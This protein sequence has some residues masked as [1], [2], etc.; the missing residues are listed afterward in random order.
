MRML[1]FV[2]CAVFLTCGAATAA[3]GKLNFK[4]TS[5]VEVPYGG[6][7]E[8][9]YVLDVF[10]IDA[11]GA[12]DFAVSGGVYDDKLDQ[13]H[14]FI[15]RNNTDTGK[16]QLFDLGDEGLTHSAWH[17]LFF[18]EGAGEQ[19][20]FVLGRNGEA[21]N[22][23]GERLAIF[24][25]TPGD[26]TLTTEP[27]FTSPFSHLTMTVTGCDIDADG[28]TEIF[29]NNYGSPL[30]DDSGRPSVIRLI[31]GKFKEGRTDK[32]VP[33]LAVHGAH[34]SV[35]FSD[36]DGDGDCDVLAALEVAKWSNGNEPT[37]PG[38]SE[39]YALLNENGV[40]SH[41]PIEAPDPHFGDHNAAFDFVMLH[42]NGDRL[43]FLLSSKYTKPGGFRGNIVQVYRLSDGAFTEVTDEVIDRQWDMHFS[44]SIR[45]ADID[46]DG[47]TDLYFSI[48]FGDIV[49]F[50]N[51]GGTFRREKVL[52]NPG[53]FSSSVAFLRNPTAKCADLAVALQNGKLVRYTCRQ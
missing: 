12:D 20:Y 23:T 14:T 39:S 10:D 46:Y 38:Q 18:R 25:V 42:E 7:I 51:L 32:W 30:K 41:E 36:I 50:R 47:D 49:I 40:I 4:R 6:K 31:D 8:E 34:N 28:T 1:P 44:N 5:V 16:P 13:L 48:Y 33:W 17:G 29:V 53:G 26:G 19:T 37:F 15:V 43:F 52:N 22:R 3:D 24:K 2:L 21:A 45:F 35:T 9:V 11:D 27:A